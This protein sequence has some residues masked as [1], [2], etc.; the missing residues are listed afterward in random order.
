LEGQK[1]TGGDLSD[2][3]LATLRSRVRNFYKVSAGAVV[4]VARKT[5]VELQDEDGVEFLLIYPRPPSGPLRFEASF[6]KELPAGHRSS[7]SV[8]DEAGESLALALHTPA[9]PVVEGV[10]QTGP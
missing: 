9:N 7:L 5:Q 4:R 2:E 1:V 3:M 6:L 8:L 10:F